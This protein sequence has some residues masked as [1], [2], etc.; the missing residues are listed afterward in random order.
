M[1]LLVACGAGS[2]PPA[3]SASGSADVKPSA[4]AAVAVQ[5][6]AGMVE[7]RY[8][9]SGGPDYIGIGTNSVWVKA[10]SGLLYR[11]DPRT[12]REV[13]HILAA[14]E[15][16]Q[17][18]G[19][20]GEEVWTCRG[21]DIVRIDTSS[22]KLGPQVVVGKVDDQANIGIGFGHAWV[23]AQPG[24]RLLGINSATNTIDVTIDLGRSCR[25]LAV[26]TTSIWVS[27]AIDG[28]LL[29][30]DPAP[31]GRGVIG[32]VA[33]LPG[34]GQ[35]STTDPAGR[36]WIAY[37]DGIARIDPASLTLT[38]A[39]DVKAEKGSLLATQDALWVRAKDR[40]LRRVDPATLALSAEF[41]A[42]QASG[43]S[44][45][46]GFGSL[47]TSAY[48]DDVVYRLKG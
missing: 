42:P 39:I 34:I 23:I 6:I 41:T 27:C 13:A 37:A 15:L 14:E 30:I 7:K 10:D 35:V 12:G 46:S 26:D 31:A 48:D 5:P 8:A 36:V 16:C 2:S 25:D 44:L 18:L 28:L 43:G 21:D 32:V 24:N 20:M 22:N 29:R 40:F 4:V 1:F 45:G 47:W 33:G 3:A 9:I 19:V 17:G 38:G 11:I